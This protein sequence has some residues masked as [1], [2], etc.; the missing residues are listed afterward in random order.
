MN[1]Y[2]DYNDFEKKSSIENAII[3]FGYDDPNSKNQDEYYLSELKSKLTLTDY[4]TLIT[5]KTKKAKSIK[6][7][8]TSQLVFM[9][10]SGES[11]YDVYPTL[12]ENSIKWFNQYMSDLLNS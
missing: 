10:S 2:K 12:A 5:R 6:A 4:P 7:G 9:W 11:S 3:H 8:K 1:P